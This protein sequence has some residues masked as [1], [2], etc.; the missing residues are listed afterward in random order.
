[1]QTISKDI[2][3]VA[4][5]NTYNYLYRTIIDPAL[6]LGCDQSVT[7]RS[8]RGKQEAWYIC[9]RAHGI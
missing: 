5:K 1:M 2:D 6:H 9:D 7:Y 8:T 4:D 3:R